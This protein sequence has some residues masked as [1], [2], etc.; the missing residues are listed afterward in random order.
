MHG[1]ILQ[2]HY[3]RIDLGM[4]KIKNCCGSRL[5]VISHKTKMADDKN[6]FVF[7]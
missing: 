4:V 7:V 5:C 3:I 1:G 6:R 2:L